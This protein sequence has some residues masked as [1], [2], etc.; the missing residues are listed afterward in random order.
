[1]KDNSQSDKA[2]ENTAEPKNCIND[3]T[4]KCHAPEGK[5]WGIEERKMALKKV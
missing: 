2:H 4:N 1:M 5:F 3:L